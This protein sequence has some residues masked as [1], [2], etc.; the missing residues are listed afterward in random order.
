[1][2]RQPLFLFVLTACAA[3]AAI[4]IGRLA[5]G[6]A[7]LFAHALN[8]RT[9]L[10]AGGWTKLL[11]LTVAA[12]FAVRSAML[13]GGGNAARTPWAMLA[14]GLGALSLGQATLVYFQTFRHVSPFPSVADVWFVIAYP[15]LIAGVIAFI[16]AYARSGFPMDG[17]AAAFIVLGLGA[18]AVAW[19][20]L[21]PIVHSSDAALPKALNVAYPALDLILL[22]PVVV[23][24]RITSRFRGGAV[25]HIWLALLAGF[26]F[27]ALGD[28]LFAY[29]TTLG[30]TRLDPAVHAMYL[31]AYGGLA[32]G[33]MVQRRLL[34]A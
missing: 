21:R 2:K 16:V 23:L 31:V 19:P 34:T 18:V 27:T 13:L 5:F 1:M 30:F 3:M 20:L 28:I 22:V 9:L 11:A 10:I 15:L 14:G 7:P 24:L 12:V 17:T 8:D 4:Y 25:W 33:A 26:V 32:A 6:S 29:F